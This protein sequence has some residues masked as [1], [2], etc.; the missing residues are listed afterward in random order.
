MY[1]CSV[2]FLKGASA[3]GELVIS[4]PFTAAYFIGSYF[5]SYN[6]VDETTP[7]NLTYSP[8]TQIM[9]QIGASSNLMFA[10]TFGSGV[11]GGYITASNIAS[12]T[13]LIIVQASILYQSTT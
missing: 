6:I 3:A 12:A 8:D 11:A 5:G 10:A 13:D 2:Y 1:H 4:I 9:G 7:T